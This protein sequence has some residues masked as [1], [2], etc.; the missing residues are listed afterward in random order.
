VQDGFGWC[1]EEAV[2][3]VKS[4]IFIK[5]TLKIVHSYH[6]KDKP[7]SSFKR[8]QV[9]NNQINLKNILKV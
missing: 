5:V 9:K 2:K 4:Y 6:L 7:L 3:Y 1:L 8:Q